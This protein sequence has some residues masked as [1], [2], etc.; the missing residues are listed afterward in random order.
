MARIFK[1]VSIII[2]AAVITI[3]SYAQI[4]DPG[5]LPTP[6][7]ALAFEPITIAA[8]DIPLPAASHTST[9]P[10]AV[11]ASAAPLEPPATIM[12][13]FWMRCSTA[14]YYPRK[15]SSDCSA[16]RPTRINRTRARSWKS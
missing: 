7:S 13:R 2:H 15:P 9:A 8:K 12:T 3:V 6:R 14:A 10:P 16:I 5:I 4:F 1:G 11:S